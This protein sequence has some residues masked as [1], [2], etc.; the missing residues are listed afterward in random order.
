MFPIPRPN[1]AAPYWESAWIFQRQL[2]AGR[3][4][5][6][7]PL[8]LNWRVRRWLRLTTSWPAWYT[9]L[10]DPFQKETTTVRIQ[11]HAK[12]KL[13]TFCIAATGAPLM[14]IFVNGV[15]ARVWDP[16]QS[17]ARTEAWPPN[18]LQLKRKTL[19]KRFDYR[20]S[21]LTWY[22]RL[23]PWDGIWVNVCIS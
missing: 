6:G 9:R 2:V 3:L 21:R 1:A 4:A 20:F 16:N 7:T 5:T 18:Q 15:F 19:R 12:E 8:E 17:I 14:V 10:A 13:P 23:R 22:L 11:T